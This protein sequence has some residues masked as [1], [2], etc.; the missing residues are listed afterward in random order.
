MKIKEILLAALL[1][2]SLSSVFGQVTYFSESTG[3]VPYDSTFSGFGAP[4]TVVRLP[5][6]NVGVFSNTDASSLMF[7]IFSPTGELQSTYIDPSPSAYPFHYITSATLTEDGSSVILAGTRITPIYT[8]EFYVAKVNLSTLLTEIVPFHCPSPY[9]MAPDVSVNSS[10]IYVV[11]PESRYSVAAKYNLDLSVAW[12][13]AFIPD[14]TDTTWS[15]HPSM[16]GTLVDDSTVVVSCKDGS[17]LSV[18]QLDAATGDLKGYNLYPYMGYTRI[19]CST[20][21]SDGNVLL[22]GL[23]DYSACVIKTTAEGDSV[24]WSKTYYDPSYLMQSIDEVIELADGRILAVGSN[25][26]GTHSFQSAVLLE[27]D[28]D[29]ITAGQMNSGGYGDY[30][31]APVADEH[32]MLTAGVTTDGFTYTGWLQYTG[33]N[34]AEACNVSSLSLV[35]NDFDL[36]V[37]TQLTTAG[38]ETWNKSLSGIVHSFTLVPSTSQDP[39]VC[40]MVTSAA[41]PSTNKLVVYPNPAASGTEAMVDFGLAGEYTLTVVDMTG[42]TVMSSSVTGSQTSVSTGSFVPGMYMVNVKNSAGSVSSQKL[43]VR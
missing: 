38:V 26:M 5:D 30:L 19:Y 11:F 36:G 23:Q 12:A 29:L 39:V 14:S 13:K 15:K 2:C 34:M 28:G 10:G 21:S 4:Q 9:T 7:R 18:A 41:K 32:G 42:K 24:L 6:G 31:G 25:G 22:G 40:S 27:A 17:Q 3:L 20:A 33:Y 16:G 8:Y 35:I 37:P 43:I 1:L